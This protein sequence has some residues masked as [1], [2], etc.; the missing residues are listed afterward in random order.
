[1]VSN[2]RN[3]KAAL[4]L[5]VTMKDETRFSRQRCYVILKIVVELLIASHAPLITSQQ[6]FKAGI[7]SSMSVSSFF[8]GIS[9]ES[10]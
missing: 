3:K 8:Y 2:Y 9:L 6:R 5:L 1:M 7:P 10:P 4:L